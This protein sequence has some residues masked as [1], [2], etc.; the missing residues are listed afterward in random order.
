MNTLHVYGQDFWHDSVHIVGDR[1][2]LLD[3]RD[4]ITR[5]LEENTS[6]KFDTYASDGE[7]YT[8]HVVNATEAFME[9]MRLPY[10]GDIAHDHRRNKK[11]PHELTS[12]AEKPPVSQPEFLEVSAEVRYWEDATVNG[13]VDTEGTLIPHRNGD[14][15]TPTIHLKTGVIQNWP[16]GYTA[17][18]YYK[19][20][21]QGEYWLRDA[22]RRLYK[23]K[24][25]YVPD[26]YLCQSYEGYGD[27]IGMDV[28]PSGEI[29]KWREPK[30]DPSEWEH[31][32]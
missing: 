25:F 3:L 30:F 7:G 16:N 1:Q 2:S 20:C 21:D 10:Y 19:V 32:Q 5:A 18:I 31:L 14:M 15:W 9:S 26:A 28:G 27:Y 8:V 24:D 4:C 17:K 22:S 11:W 29:L 12:K 23:Y 13:I 6:D